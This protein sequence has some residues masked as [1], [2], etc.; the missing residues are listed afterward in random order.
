M[1]QKDSMVKF[2]LKDY[3]LFW[4]SGFSAGLVLGS[5]FPFSHRAIVLEALF[6]GLLLLIEFLTLYYFRIKVPPVKFLLLAVLPFIIFMILGHGVLSAHSSGREWSILARLLSGKNLSSGDLIIEGRIASHPQSINGSLYFHLEADKLYIKDKY[7]GVLSFTGL[8][9]EVNIR[10]TGDPGT[11]ARDEYIKIRGALS[12]DGY[13]D[14]GSRSGNLII[15]TNPSFME[16][17]YPDKM[18]SRFFGLRKRVYDCLKNTYYLNLDFISAGLSEAIILGNRNNIPQYLLTNFKKAGIYHLFAIS[19]LHLSF[20]IGFIYL[21]FKKLKRSWLLF[22]IIIIFLASYNFL[23]GEK[24]SMIRASMGVI[25]I[26]IAGSWKREYSL[27][28]ILYFTYIVMMILDPSFFY[29]LGF[30]LSFGAMAA[31]VFIYPVLAGASGINGKTAQKKRNSIKTIA[32]VTLSIQLFLFPV[33]AYYFGEVSIAA[34]A[35]NIIVLPIFYMLLLIL[36]LSSGLA[37]LWPPL[38]GLALKPGAILFN[39]ILKI[40]N[41]TG[42]YDFYMIKFEDL[43]PGYILIYYIALMAL[44]A[45]FAKIIRAALKHKR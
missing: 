23:V 5:R 31:I 45:A 3:Y 28:I 13:R 14:P 40:V 30:W 29:D 10:S 12:W 6:L 32:L 19:G 4:V 16:K 8:G 11:F 1:A 9:E 43:T 18:S 26:L 25:F 17:I 37:I 21:L 33:L 22:I 38:G 15:K 44:L 7:Q 41:F 24:A 42:G 35:L 27:R 2:L 36:I 34:L 20:F 39:I